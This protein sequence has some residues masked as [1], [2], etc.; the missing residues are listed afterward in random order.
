M[1]EISEKAVEDAAK[2]IA[3]SMWAV[4]DFLTDS[5]KDGYRQA[6]RAALTAMGGQAGPRQIVDAEPPLFD[7][8]GYF[9]VEAEAQQ[10]EAQAGGAVP[11]ALWCPK[12]SAPHVDEGEWATRPHK[13]HQCQS[14]GHEWRPFPHP[15][16][17]VAH[18]GAPSAVPEKH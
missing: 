4:W 6:A 5:G 10:P 9:P 17:G 16:V 13:T 8:H 12:C 7:E 14:C 3:G 18:V 2:A 1:N 15:T 11:L